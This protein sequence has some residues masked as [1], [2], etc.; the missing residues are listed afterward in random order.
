[1]REHPGSRCHRL[2]RV[3]VA[4]QRATA[5]SLYWID[6]R[7]PTLLVELSDKVLG[8]EVVERALGAA[9][10]WAIRLAEDHDGVVVDQLLG[11]LCG[12]HVICGL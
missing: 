1:M 7:L 12:G 11:F 8:A 2:S 5:Q 10:V 6:V 3:S 9:A 4:A